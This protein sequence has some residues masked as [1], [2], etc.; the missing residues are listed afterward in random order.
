M[1]SLLNDKFS[2]NLLIGLITYKALGN[3]KAQSVLPLY[4]KFDTK[5]LKEK[6]K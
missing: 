6:Y 2:K 5:P 3:K 4:N 1:Y